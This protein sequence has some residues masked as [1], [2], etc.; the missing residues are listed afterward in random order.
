MATLS[1]VSALLQTVHFNR[2]W[3]RYLS[4][5]LTD[6]A[7][8]TLL[9]FRLRAGQTVTVCGSVRST[10]NEIYLHR[11]YDVPG[12]EFDKCR[13]I[14][15]FGANMGL[16]ASYIASRAPA[17]TISCFEASSANFPLLQQN[18][19]ANCERAQAYRMAVSTTCGSRR[20]SLAGEA[21]QYRLDSQ[22]GDNF[23]IV[24]CMDLANIFTLTGADVCDFLKMD[25]EG[26]ELPFLLE[27]PLDVLRRVRA[28][29]MEWHY[30]EDQLVHVQARLAKAGF[31][32]MVDRVGHAR[33]QLMLKA[34]QAN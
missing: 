8:D 23:E 20:F 16:F 29:A 15:D 22:A 1:H 34:R 24:E 4:A 25:I 32:T 21:G 19:R 30:P 5:R 14:F 33:K 2:D 13:H 18:L 11:V 31:E 27:T 28:M 9:T 12:V 7:D 26:E 10:L 17:A 6:P 3:F